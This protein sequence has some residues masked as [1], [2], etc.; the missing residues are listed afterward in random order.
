[1]RLV[2]ALL[3]LVAASGTTRAQDAALPADYEPLQRFPAAQVKVTTS[4]GTHE[5]RV[6]IARTPRHRSQ[7]LMFVRTLDPDRGMLFLF[8][9][10]LIT[11]FWMQNTYVA[12]DMLFVRA[13][14]RIANIAASTRPLTTDPYTSSEPVI[15]VLELAGG[16]AARLGIRTGD[17]VHLPPG[18]LRQAR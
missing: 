14:G 15:A 10:P 3:L 12:L 8:P 16:T 4:L 1:M 6:W 7:G 2:L 5:F 9:A 13:N 18:S 11:S 17:R